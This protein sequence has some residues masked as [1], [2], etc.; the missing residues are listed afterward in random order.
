MR[1]NQTAGCKLI[2]PQ[3][4]L[5]G[6]V[7]L[8]IDSN[9]QVPDVRFK[10]MLEKAKQHALDCD[11]TVYIE[12]KEQARNKVD[13]V[14]LVVE[15]LKDVQVKANIGIGSAADQDAVAALGILIQTMDT[16][17]MVLVEAMTH[18]DKIGGIW[19]S[20]L[21]VPN[22]CTDVFLLQEWLIDRELI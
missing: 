18:S 1:K 19:P 12:L 3:A 22:S 8:R 13:A 21:K 10:D 16:C 17:S 14:L 6:H 4:T 20:M 5:S 2:G 7:Y 11:C 15:A 9:W